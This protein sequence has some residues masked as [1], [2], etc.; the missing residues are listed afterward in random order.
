MDFVWHAAWRCVHTKKN[1]SAYSADWPL[2]QLYV[3]FLRGSPFRLA[4]GT[5]ISSLLP[6]PRG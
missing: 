6:E 3:D 5:C 2:G 1:D 4:A